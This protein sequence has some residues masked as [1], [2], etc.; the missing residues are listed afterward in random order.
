[1]K[2]RFRNLLDNSVKRILATVEQ[3]ISAEVNATRGKVLMDVVRLDRQVTEH[4]SRLED[5]VIRML[6]R[7][8]CDSLL[9]WERDAAVRSIFRKAN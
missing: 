1:M 4:L 6:H 9:D 5:D 8:D 3:R 7:C 2:Q